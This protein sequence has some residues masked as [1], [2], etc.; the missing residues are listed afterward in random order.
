MNDSAP[1][2]TYSIEYGLDLALSGA[3]FARSIECTVWTL[4]VQPE[5]FLHRQCR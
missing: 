2:I 1:S 5:W 4:V 3:R